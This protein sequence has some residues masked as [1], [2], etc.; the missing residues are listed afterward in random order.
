MFPDK[1]RETG[2]RVHLLG[3][4]DASWSSGAR[5]TRAQGR[6]PC[7][8]RPRVEAG[9]AYAF[10]VPHTRRSGSTRSHYGDG[11]WERPARRDP[12]AWATGTFRACSYAVLREV[13]WT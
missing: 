11:P 6:D 8:R 3:A 7:T 10:A 12:K 9:A 1:L 2:V 4:L 13:P 5:V